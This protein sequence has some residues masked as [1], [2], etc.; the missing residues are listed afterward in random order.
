MENKTAKHQ[1][2]PASVDSKCRVLGTKVANFAYSNPYRRIVSYPLP[3]NNQWI[4][5]NRIHLL[6]IM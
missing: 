4:A 5:F 3:C 6:Y 2:N 1:M